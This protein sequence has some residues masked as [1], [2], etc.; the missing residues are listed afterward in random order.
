MEWPAF[1][2]DSIMVSFRIP[3]PL[4]RQT[5]KISSRDHQIAARRWQA[6]KTAGVGTVSPLRP[7]VKVAPQTVFYASRTCN[8]TCASGCG[9]SQTRVV[10]VV[11]MIEI[12]ELALCSAC[13]S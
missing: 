4:H 2:L 5:L 11:F 9:A 6:R 1:L 7:K 3:L 10:D 8:G 13:P 12:F